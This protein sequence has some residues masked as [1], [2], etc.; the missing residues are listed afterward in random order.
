MCSA[1]HDF[2]NGI[3][4]IRS[5]PVHEKARSKTNRKRYKIKDIYITHLHQNYQ[6]D[7]LILKSVLTCCAS[8][9]AKLCLFETKKRRKDSSRSKVISSTNFF[10]PSGGIVDLFLNFSI[11]RF[12]NHYY[13][14]FCRS[15][16]NRKGWLSKRRLNTNRAMSLLYWETNFLCPYIFSLEADTW[17]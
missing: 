16:S 9:T 17:Q 10:L 6:V 5:V 4:S 1:D 15:P 7:S 13:H 12:G 8:K 3:E 14:H 2:W 11:V